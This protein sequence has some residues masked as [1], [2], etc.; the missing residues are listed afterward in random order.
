MNSK[1]TNLKIGRYIDRQINKYRSTVTC[2][3]ITEFSD[4][5]PLK[6]AMLSGLVGPSSDS[7]IY[8]MCPHAENSVPSAPS[9][10]GNTQ[11][12]V[13]PIPRDPI[14]SGFR[15]HLCALN[16]HKFMEGHTHL[17]ICIF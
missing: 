9:T 17:N 3:L 2:V 16:A 11:L 12:P 10:S 6:S 4:V 13:I 8:S 7:A 1:P 15:G 14:L 5:S